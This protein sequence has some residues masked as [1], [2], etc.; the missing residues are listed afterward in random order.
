MSLISRRSSSTTRFFEKLHLFWCG[1]Q[2]S[3]YFLVSIGLLTSH[4]LYQEYQ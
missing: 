4:L 3:L 2:A 1:W